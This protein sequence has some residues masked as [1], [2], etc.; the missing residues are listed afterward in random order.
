MERIVP[1]VAI[2]GRPNVGKSTL[3]NRLVG[4]RAALVDDRPGVTR[5]RLF[6]EIHHDDRVLRV[7]DT[8][9]FV[10]DAGD[11]LMA[12]MR[13]QTRLAIEEADLV[14]LVVDV[15]AG[16][17]PADAELARLLTKSGRPVIVVANK[18]DA[19]D[20]DARADEQYALGIPRVLAV[21][22]E[23]GRGVGELCDLLVAELDAPE[24]ELA[25]A[26][27]APV[28][29]ADG[30]P[31]EGEESRVEW[32]GGAVR[33]AV[34]GRPNVGKSSLVN[35]L[36]GEERMLESDLPGTTRDA[37]DT[38]LELKG[39]RYVLVDTAGIR[40]QR[41]IGDPL[42]DLAVM[43]ALRS[44]DRADVVLVVLDAGQ[45]PAEQDAR[46][47]AQAV[48]RGKGVLLVA[49][50]W[51]LLP[52]DRRG[53]DVVEAIRWRL[54]F[55]DFAPVLSTSAKTGR[56]V[57]GILPAVLAAQRERHR[58]VGT[59]ALNRFFAEVVESHPPPVSR[60]KRP[61]LFYA[62]QP[63]V[64]PPTFVFAASHPDSVPD[65]YR[66]YLGNALR[67]RFGFEGT[68]VWVK[69]RARSK[70]P[71]RARRRPAHRDRSR[72]R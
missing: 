10:S 36:L 16:V 40:R 68:P 15:Q 22:A 7:V 31:G 26:E 5:D 37:V 3:F 28:A 27:S 61:R 54:P 45:E 66:R 64:R 50:K 52:R 57:D 41:S 20:H 1:L 51:D 6:A 58:R 29:V 42:E 19:P 38:E 14:L 49:N 46:V 11:D 13:L 60:G 71:G 44:A 21:S 24:A 34:I 9:G 30:E 72:R 4:R 35:C 39:Q 62:S 17:I 25:G 47:A 65:S 70:A 63:L 53:R 48:D 55:V 2:V 18:A 56:G 59:A 32:D 23:H 12:R 8:G 33:V 67:Q 43:M 69:L